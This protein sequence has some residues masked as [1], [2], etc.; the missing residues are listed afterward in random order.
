[1]A[2][3]SP[4]AAEAAKVLTAGGFG[5]LVT[6][7]LRHPGSIVRAVCMVA[8]GMG[9]AVVFTDIVAGIFDLPV[10]P[11]AAIIGLIGKALAEAALR[12][13]EKVDLSAWAKRKGE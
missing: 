1:M 7:Y 12:A 5:A 13:A 6:V 2:D 9:L 3:F 10:I 4:E 8:I 11:V